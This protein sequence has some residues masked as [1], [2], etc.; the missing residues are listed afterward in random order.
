MAFGK[1]ISLFC[2]GS[3]GSF[4]I[5]FSALLRMYAELASGV[6][7]AF[8]SLLASFWAVSPSALS[9]EGS[10]RCFHSPRAWLPGLTPQAGLQAADWLPLFLLAQCFLPHQS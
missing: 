10:K 6:G 7:A 8:T 9:K 5:L 1:Q 4:T 3:P 2:I